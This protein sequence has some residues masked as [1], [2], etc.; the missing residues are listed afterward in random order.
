MFSDHVK[1]WMG[2]GLLSVVLVLAGALQSTAQVPYSTARHMTRSLVWISF[3]NW[4]T[5]GMH[6]H[7]TPGRVM[8]RMSYPGN[9]Y[10][11]YA[12]LGTE[13]FEEYWGSKGWGHAE[14]KTESNMHSAGEGVLVLTNVD[15]EKFVS[16]TGPRTPTEDVEP[17]I[18][19]IQNQKEATWGVQTTVPD[20]GVNPGMI[21]SNWW[22]GASPQTVDRTQSRPYEIHNFDYSM[23]PPVQTAGEEIHI[24]QWST[25]HDVWVTRKAHSYSH[26]DFDDFFI[27][28]LEFENRGNKQ[29]ND[30]YFGVMNTFYVNN[31]G[32]SYRWGHEGGLVRYRRAP[33]G[34]DDWYKY[35]ESPNF[36]PNPLSGLSASQFQGK[37]INYQWDGNTNASFE[38]DTGD[39]YYRDLENGGGDFPNSTARPEG[40]PISLAYQFM[41]PLAFRNTGPSHTF[42]AADAAEGFVDPQGDPLSHWYTAHARRN[43]DDPT[44]GSVSMADQYDIFTGPNTPDPTSEQMQ[45]SD[46]IWGPYNLAPGDKAKVVLVY[47]FGSAADMAPN[48][49]TGYPH[50]MIQWSFNFGNVGD[51]ERKQRL[52]RGEEA[53]L[54]HLDHAQFVY[55]AGFDIPDSPPDVEFFQTSNAQAKIVLEWPNTADNAIHPDYGM[56]DVAGY[57]VYRSIWQE[58][59]P[60]ILKADIPKGSDSGG[61][62]SWVDEESLAGFSFGYSVRAYATPK[63]NWSNSTGMTINDLPPTVRAHLENGLEGGWSAA[64]QRMVVPGTPILAANDDADALANPVTVVPNPFD[65]SLEEA[66]YQGSK[67]LRFLGVPRKSRISIFTVSGDLI[68]VI[69]HDDPTAGEAAWLL[70]DR[71]LTGEAT[72][73]L[74]F[75]VVESLMPASMGQKSKGAFVIHR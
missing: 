17:Q 3:T 15:G 9:T 46:Q 51:D 10:A 34:M 55:N 28:E 25:K 69:D 71:F 56:A 70:K 13:E 27:L 73:A 2:L 26:Q 37:F 59:G 23:Y 54:R 8:M 7:V 14:Q 72:S 38:E 12:L 60:W 63:T 19:D 42:N 29:L 49:E 31:H 36:M 64:E 67:K 74:Y 47:G 16:V 50:D 24:S 66:N 57:R 61:K 5:S 35:T 44:R 6:Y 20:R 52:A 1:R 41:A 53:M 40:T 58:T 62:Y 75:F 68:Q 48:T 33:G 32:T 30:T 18:Y 45:W 43:I 11:L 65:L 21:K 22:S 4:G 39:P